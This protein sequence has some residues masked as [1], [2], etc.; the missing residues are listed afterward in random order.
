M[1]SAGVRADGLT[2]LVSS[3]EAASE[4][5]QDFTQP[6]REATSFLAGAAA[7]NT[8]RRSGALAAGHRADASPKVGTVANDRV[9]A[10]PIHWGWP[11]RNI[12]A[13]PWLTDTLTRSQEQVVA[14][15]AEHVQ[16][17]INTIR[18]A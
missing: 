13:Q 5:L 7:V 1:S 2:Q 11:A 3:L 4:Q 18:G 17:T 10:G 6:H 16:R 12:R 8:P 9:Y 15:Y 14:P